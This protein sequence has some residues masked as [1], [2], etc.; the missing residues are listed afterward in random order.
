MNL[1]LPRPYD[2]ELV[3]SVFARHFAYMQPTVIVS[4]H[5]SIDNHK[6]F[7]TRYVRGAAQLA[8]KTRLI[9]GLSGLQILDRHTLLPFNGAFLQPE[10]HLKCAECFMTNNPKNGATALGMGNSSTADTRFLRVT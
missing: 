6:W 8:E 7:S 1:S 5:R 2:D 3:Y 9:W 10:V 4:A